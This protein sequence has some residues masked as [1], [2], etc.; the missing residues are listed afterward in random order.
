MS[1]AKDSLNNAGWPIWSPWQVLMEMMSG[2]SGASASGNL[3]Q[4]ILPGW[5]FGSVINVTER[6]SSA[7]DTERDIVAAHSYGR[8]LGRVIEALTA[9]IAERPEGAPSNEAFDKLIELQGKIKTI[10]SEAAAS[11]IERIKSDL[12]LL[13]AEKPEEYEQFIAALGK[14]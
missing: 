14:V 1:D 10:K 2:R 6:N 7:P 12:A 4:P 11:R 13:K 9:L 3:D 5:T 8:Q